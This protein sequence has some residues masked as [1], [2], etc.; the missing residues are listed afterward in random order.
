MEEGTDNEIMEC[1]FTSDGDYELLNEICERELRKI[2]SDLILF[3]Y[4]SNIS[5]DEY[6]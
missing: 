3:R 4:K 6:L 5:V 2:K 1:L